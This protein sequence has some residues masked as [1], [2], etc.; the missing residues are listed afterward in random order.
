MKGTFRNWSW[1]RQNWVSIVDF[2]VWRVLK[3]L[4]DGPRCVRDLMREGVS[5][6]ILYDIVLPRL[7]K[8]KAI[9]ERSEPLHYHRRVIS[10]TDNGARLLRAFDE[11]GSVIEQSRKDIKG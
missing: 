3:L 10:L 1:E 9:E 6:S 8:V 4:R 2:N 7:R 11:I 5:S